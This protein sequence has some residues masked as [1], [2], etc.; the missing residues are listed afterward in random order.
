MET[1]CRLDYRQNVD[2]F[3]GLLAHVGFP[4]SKFL[5][6]IYNIVGRGYSFFLKEFHILIK[7][8]FYWEN[9]IL[10]LEEL[11]Y[12]RKCWYLNVGSKDIYR[13]SN[14]KFLSKYVANLICFYNKYLGEMGSL[15]RFEQIQI[16][17]SL[18]L[19]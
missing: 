16:L 4:L 13:V 1:M 12:C 11:F 17:H 18:S 6:S 7:Q 3:G 5:T 15:P 19:V 2:D 14:K 9:V 10:K 8:I